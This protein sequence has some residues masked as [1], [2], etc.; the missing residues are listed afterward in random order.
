MTAVASDADGE[1]EVT[2]TSG[3]DT[4]DGIFHDG[5]MRRLDPKSAGGFEE[6]VW[7]RLARQPQT[8][9]LDAI[10][11][12]IKEVRQSGRGY[13]R[14]AVLARRDHGSLDALRFQ[15]ANQCHDMHACGI[16]DDPVKIEEHCLD[17][18]KPKHLGRIVCMHTP[19]EPQKGCRSVM[20]DQRTGLI[21][22]C[23]NRN[24]SEI[25][26]VEEDWDIM[27]LRGQPF[28]V[29]SKMRTVSLAFVLGLASVLLLYRSAAGVQV[30]TRSIAP[31]VRLSQTVA[32]IRGAVVCA[33]CRVQ[34]ARYRYPEMDRLYELAGAEQPVVLRVDWVNDPVTWYL[35]SFNE[36][37]PV[38]ADLRVMQRLTDPTYLLRPL[39]LNI[40]A[41]DRGTLTIGTVRFL[42]D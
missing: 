14:C 7:C 41:G 1:T 35:L 38:Q 37:L 21:P 5:G 16:G 28:R 15:S 26:T 11:A 22:A 10:D 23:L 4:S 30:P 12:N 24:V 29:V 18:F 33:G 17:V 32:Y 27:R 3:L 40:T 39:E 20:F 8:R 42:G 31:S 6:R 19:K 25:A 13:H 34:E 2:V 9:T 36:R